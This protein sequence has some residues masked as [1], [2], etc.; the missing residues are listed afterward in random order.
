MGKEPPYRD[1]EQTGAPLQQGRQ[2]EERI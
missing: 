2:R 1:R